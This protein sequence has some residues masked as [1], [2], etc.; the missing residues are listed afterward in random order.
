MIVY[1]CNEKKGRIPK[2]MRKIFSRINS[3]RT[4][5]PDGIPGIAIDDDYLNFKDSF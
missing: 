5:I 3:Y 1:K 2:G 4:G